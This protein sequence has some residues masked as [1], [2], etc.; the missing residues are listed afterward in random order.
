M[1]FRLNLASILV[2][3]IVH[4]VDVETRSPTCVAEDMWGPLHA[5]RHLL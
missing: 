3:S 1:I 2:T 5:P 4:R